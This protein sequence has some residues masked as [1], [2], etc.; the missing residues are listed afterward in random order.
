MSKSFA[1]RHKCVYHSGTMSLK[2]RIK[3]SRFILSCVFLTGY[4]AYTVYA[5]YYYRNYEDSRIGT[6]LLCLIG[7][8]LA[9]N[10]VITFVSY[11][12]NLMDKQRPKIHRFLKM[13]KYTFQLVASAITVFLVI[14]TVQNTSVF[15]LI[16]SFISIPFLLWSLFVNVL[17]EI[18]DRLFRGFGKREFVQQEVK[19]EEGETVDVRA[20]IV[21]LDAEQ[22]VKMQMNPKKKKL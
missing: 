2:K 17:A 13:T 1:K 21:N 16:M 9:L 7:A 20:L 6:I 18:F 10:I 19:N 14:S 12:I 11:R 5:I 22:N 4:A 3:V 15:S 8:A